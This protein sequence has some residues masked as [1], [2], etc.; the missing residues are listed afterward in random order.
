MGSAEAPGALV[1]PPPGSDGGPRTPGQQSLH[2]VPRPNSLRGHVRRGAGSMIPHVV[3]IFFTSEGRHLRHMTGIV[4]RLIFNIIQIIFITGFLSLSATKFK[5]KSNSAV[6]EYDSCNKLGL[7]DALWAAR[8][9]FGTFVV[10]W[11]LRRYIEKRHRTER[12]SVEELELGNIDITDPS[13]QH[14]RWGTEVRGP[15]ESIPSPRPPAA[16]VPHLP[17]PPTN[18][19]SESPG[20]TRPPALVPPDPAPT[21]TS[22]SAQRRAR[23]RE[24]RQPAVAADAT[25]DR[26]DT[27]LTATGLI[28]FVVNHIWLYTTVHTCR[29]DAPHVWYLGLGIASLGYLIVLELLL[30]AF[31]VFVLGPILLLIL[32][33]VMLCLGRPVDRHGNVIVRAEIPKMEQSLI[34]KIPLVVFIPPTESLVGVSQSSMGPNTSFDEP[35]K[36]LDVGIPVAAAAATKPPA[37]SS[38]TASPPRRPRLAWL[39]KRKGKTVKPTMWS[40]AKLVTEGDPRFENSEHPFVV[41]ETNRAM[42]PICLVEFVEPKRREGVPPAPPRPKTPEPQSSGAGEASSSS[43]AGEDAASGEPTASKGPDEIQ[44]VTTEATP[45]VEEDAGIPGEPLRLLA[46][47]HVFHVI[48][49]NVAANR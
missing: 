2:A 29:L 39:S 22:R 6:S 17:D 19:D 23:S 41:L 36:K 7:W 27:F 38:N 5:S 34:D 31:I 33:L 46:C 9:S 4:S 25:F 28:H 18:Q 32:N 15:S 21:S 13:D 10:V 3:R 26:M 49:S 8:A 45:E 44:Q 12:R 24:T 30:I 20:I 37:T 47:G 1:I 16:T 42:C 11:E 40:D 14:L 48:G 43:Q 35:T